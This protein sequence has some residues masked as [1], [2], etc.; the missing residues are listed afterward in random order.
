M[1]GTWAEKQLDPKE[2]SGEPWGD[3][4]EGVLGGVK[5][6]CKGPGVG[7]CLVCWKNREEAC[8]A[9]AE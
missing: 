9:E 2:V 5:S 4:G 8:M 1:R 3:L 7:P 6:V